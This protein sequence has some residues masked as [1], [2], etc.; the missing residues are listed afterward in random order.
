MRERVYGY[1]AHSAAWH[2]GPSTGN[3]VSRARSRV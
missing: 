1:S 2:V 3:A